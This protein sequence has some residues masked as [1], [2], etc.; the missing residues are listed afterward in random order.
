[1]SLDALVVRRPRRKV[2]VSYHHANDRT[3]YEQFVGMFDST[4]EVCTDNSVRQT[5]RSADSDYVIRAIRE[6]YITGSS[7][8]IVLCGPHTPWR[9]FVDWE[10]KATLD[11]EH[12]LIGVKLPTCPLNA[13]HKYCVPDRLFE[14]IQSGY[15]IWAEWPSILGAHFAVGQW[16]ESALSA[17]KSLIRNSRPLMYRNG[18]SPYPIS[19]DQYMIR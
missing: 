4:Y 9:K 10:I 6:R 18:T 7:C 16:I 11:A 2:F 5:I 14:N 8:T 1:M 3:Y 19:L 15:A 12:A 13:Q 17:S